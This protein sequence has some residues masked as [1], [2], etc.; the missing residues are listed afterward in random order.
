MLKS[1]FNVKT[2]LEKN[3]EIIYIYMT[4][5]WQDALPANSRHLQTSNTTT[6][7]LCVLNNPYS[8]TVVR[9]MLIVCVRYLLTI[10][11]RISLSLLIFWK[12]LE[13]LL[14][15]TDNIPARIH[16]RYSRDLTFRVFVKIIFT[17]LT[18]NVTQTVN[19]ICLNINIYN[20]EHSGVLLL[21]WG[22]RQN[23]V[24]TSKKGFTGLTPYH[25]PGKVSTF[26]LPCNQSI[27]GNC[28]SPQQ[29]DLIRH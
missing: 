10:P 14:W 27:V 4:N 21:I 16:I 20:H 24:K 7:E 25:L 29:K 17:S 28:Y 12:R 23:N 19:W 13:A 6:G 15:Y 11:S 2:R 18:S 26:F 9:K 8:L 1:F 3:I 5:C 22:N